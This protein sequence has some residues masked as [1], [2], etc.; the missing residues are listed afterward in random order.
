MA[1]SLKTYS[2]LAA[3][4]RQPTE[5]EIV[6][7]GLHHHVERGFAVPTPASE[8]Y[9]RHQRGSRWPTVNPCSARSR[10]ALPP[11]MQKLC[12]PMTGVSCTRQ[13]SPLLIGCA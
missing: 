3:A 7:T 12:L 11:S 8:W 5:Y 10:I 13:R 2:H 6:T 4:R 9:A 1:S